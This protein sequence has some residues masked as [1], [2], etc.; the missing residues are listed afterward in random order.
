[1]Y[2]NVLVTKPFDHTFTYK[3]KRGQI[4]EVGSVVNVPFGK[5]KDEIGIVYDFIKSKSR[6]ISLDDKT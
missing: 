2:C 5:K 3:V 6:R 1:M 4:L